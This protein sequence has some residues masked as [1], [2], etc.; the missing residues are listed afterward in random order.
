MLRLTILLL[1]LYLVLSNLGSLSLYHTGG[2]TFLNL[3]RLSRKCSI[4]YEYK[5]PTLKIPPG[6]VTHLSKALNTTNTVVRG[7][8]V[9]F[10][11]IPVLGSIELTPTKLSTEFI[12][13]PNGHHYYQG[14]ITKESDYYS[15]TVE[16]GDENSVKA[17]I[18]SLE[19]FAVIQNAIR[20]NVEV[21]PTPLFLR[22]LMMNM[23]HPENRKWMI[24]EN[25]FVKCSTY[26]PGFLK[27]LLSI[28]DGHFDYNPTIDELFEDFLIRQT[29]EKLGL[30]ERKSWNYP[31]EDIRAFIRSSNLF[32]SKFVRERGNWALDITPV[33]MSWKPDD[34]VSMALS[35]HLKSGNYVQFREFGGSVDIAIR[36]AVGIVKVTEEYGSFI[37]D[38]L[39]SQVC[40]LELKTIKKLRAKIL[41]NE[42]IV[43][44]YITWDPETCSHTNRKRSAKVR[45]LYK[46][47]NLV[48]GYIAVNLYGISPL[49]LPGQSVVWHQRT[50]HRFNIIGMYNPALISFN[51]GHLL[52]NKYFESLYYNTYCNGIF[53]K[54]IHVKDI[55]SDGFTKNSV[56]LDVFLEAANKTFP[57][58][59]VVK[60]IW[61]YN[62]AGDVLSHLL[63][64]HKIMKSYLDSPYPNYAQKVEKLN[65]GCEPVEDLYAILRTGMHFQAWK[66]ERLLNNI[67][68]TMLQEF[69]PPFREYRVE[70]Y[71]GQ[72][73]FNHMS[74][75]EHEDKAENKLKW[76]SRV[77]EQFTKCLGKIPERIRGIPLTSDVALLKDMKTVK[78]FETNPGGNGYLYHHE[79][80]LLRQ[81]NKFLKEYQ[82]LVGWDSESTEIQR[83]LTPEEQMLYISDLLKQWGIDLGK[84]ERR[85]T[86]L[87][88]RIIDDLY[89]IPKGV[90]LQRINS[91]SP[92][93][94]APARVSIGKRYK[95]IRYALEYIRDKYEK[96]HLN[97]Q[98]F[99][100]FLKSSSLL[101]EGM[102]SHINDLHKGIVKRFFSTNATLISSVLNEIKVL[103]NINMNDQGKIELLQSMTRNIDL[104]HTFQ[105]MNLPTE[106][107]ESELKKAHALVSQVPDVGTKMFPRFNLVSYRQ[108]E[109]QIERIRKSQLQ[110]RELTDL[111]NNL[112]EF[113][114]SIDILR[115]FER[116]GFALPGV[117]LSDVLKNWIPVLRT[118]YEII[119][120][121][122]AK[123]QEAKWIP[124]FKSVVHTIS[125]LLQVL[126]DES[127]FQ[128]D[129]QLYSLEYQYLIQAMPNIQATKNVEL[130]GNALDA[131]MTFSTDEDPKILDLINGARNVIIA[132]QNHHGAW[133][134]HSHVNLRATLAG[135]RGLIEHSYLATNPSKFYQLV[136]LEMYRKRL[137]DIGFLLK[138][139]SHLDSPPVK[140][141][142]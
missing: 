37:H 106:E 102:S 21:D 26:T 98:E 120:S 85:F 42:V 109:A 107:L 113:A 116:S 15:S 5:N 87:R 16:T 23:F 46:L 66:I 128:L 108:L 6:L 20:V 47:D 91:T 29:A 10:L 11:D 78:I 50:E 24:K 65:F 75:D 54:T 138:P 55:L 41:K 44:K 122:S 27:K 134:I 22:N 132:Q 71:A 121:A 1:S 9:H 125:H 94:Y 127:F 33:L 100:L 32:N 69:T 124:L 30:Q 38:S 14:W 59:W 110:D 96:I 126:S 61:D 13:S 70:C 19:S 73:P 60:G 82:Q 97:Q 99:M 64:H 62:G 25:N 80:T 81:H 141:E 17:L 58:G 104:V 112:E 52:E 77:L 67:N 18:E 49:V 72:C 36:R 51:V 117:N 131:I 103:S 34:E 83:G 136:P 129:T 114:D 115:N 133:I 79:F 130:I 101:K 76:K 142:L 88:D 92:Q 56:S 7:E 74:D 89:I 31:L 63:Q 12:N 28:K 53:P 40:Y 57:K 105:I 118:A 135:I 95:Q 39:V 45:K 90:D 123:P 111:S 48:L 139:V 2:T 84:Y 119:P 137:A 4:D 35:L 3:R 86:M 8:N 43:F 68:D 140:D 93:T